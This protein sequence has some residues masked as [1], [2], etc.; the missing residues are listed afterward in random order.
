MHQVSSALDALKL[1]PAGTH[2]VAAPGCGAPSTLLAALPEAAPGRG[3]TLA[4]GILLGDPG[5]LS[6]VLDGDLA[7]RTWHVPPAARTLVAS[8]AVDYVPLR[9]SR[10]AAHLADWGVGAALVRISPPDA[11]G[12]V[13]LGGSVGYSL[14][15]LELATVRLAE[16]DPAV[17]RTQGESTVPLSVFDALVD[18]AGAM[19]EYVSA[20]PDATSRLIAERV[21]GL[22]PRDPTLQIGIGS[23][24]ESVFAGL[25]AA[26]L[27]RVRFEGMGSDAMVELFQQGVLDAREVVPRPALRSPELMGTSR[28]MRFADDNPAIGLYPSASSHDTGRLGALER[29][30]SVNAAIEVDLLGQV[31]VESVRGRPVA[32]VGGALDFVEAASRSRGGLRIVALASAA[33]DGGASRIVPR[34]STVS[35]PSACTDTVVT[36]YG[37]ARLEGLSVRERAEALIAIA[38]PDYRDGLAEAAS[39]DGAAS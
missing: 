32:G 16:I 35:L 2:L 33:P 19:P 10:V 22:V 36:E 1:V 29:L 5:F 27:G 7:Y 39:G 18:S 31:N 14:A 8:G 34:V 4:T 28:L 12:T 6:A 20:V 37:V 15:A 21:L 30:V 17:P 25:A 3:W 11:Q 38:H 23:I 26:D 13:S 24:P 9:A